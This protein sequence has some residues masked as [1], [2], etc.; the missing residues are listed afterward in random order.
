[1]VISEREVQKSSP[2]GEGANPYHNGDKAF[3]MAR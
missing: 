1:M 2:V 3:S